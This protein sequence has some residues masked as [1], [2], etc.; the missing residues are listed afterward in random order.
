[1]ELLTAVF[2]SRGGRCKNE[3]SVYCVQKGNSA[4]AAVADGLGM[5]GGGDIASQTAVNALSQ[6]FF[7]DSDISVDS[8]RRCF[9]FANK[10]V[11]KR[12]TLDCKMKSTAAALF[13]RLGQGVFAHVGDSRIYHFRDGAL[14]F[15]TTDHSVSQMAVDSGKINFSQ[16]RFHEDR[17]R[18]L[19]AF[20]ADENVRIEIRE[21]TDLAAGRDAFLLCSDGFWEYVM[22]SEMEVDLAKSASP[23][24]WV[25]Y[26]LGRIGGRIGENNDNLSCVAI[27]YGRDAEKYKNK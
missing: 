8:I 23:E 5:H 12:Q 6:S 25:S 22:E 10:A 26:L 16:I 20:G 3:D 11:L 4:L 18:L 9:E 19:R 24:Q 1:M 27:F 2:T 21:L 7:H 13:L 14:V 15:Q 17:N